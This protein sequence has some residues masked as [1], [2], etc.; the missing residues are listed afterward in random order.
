VDLQTRFSMVSF[1]WAVD[2]HGR[3]VLGEGVRKA[4]ATIAMTLD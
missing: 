2:A 1:P 3:E 4:K